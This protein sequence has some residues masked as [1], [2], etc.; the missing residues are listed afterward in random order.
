MNQLLPLRL[1]CHH[2]NALQMMA[3]ATEGGAEKG[4]FSITQ[5]ISS[6]NLQKSTNN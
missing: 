2:A 5:A 6:A 1:I 4:A 3:M